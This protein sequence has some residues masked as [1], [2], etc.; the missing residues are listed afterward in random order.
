MQIERVEKGKRNCSLCSDR[1]PATATVVPPPADE[2]GY[3]VQVY[4][5]TPCF[6][7]A[8]VQWLLEWG[9]EGKE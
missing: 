2:T 3:Y 1:K 7:K 6:I 4:Y 5:C 8:M 9:K